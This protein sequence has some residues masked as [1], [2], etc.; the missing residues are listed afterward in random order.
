MELFV[1]D[2]GWWVVGPYP[3]NLAVSYPPESSPDLSKPINGVPLAPREGSSVLR[4]QPMRPGIADIEHVLTPR[5]DAASAAV[6]CRYRS[7]NAVQDFRNAGLISWRNA[8]TLSLPKR[9]G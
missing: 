8:I 1:L 9:A 5:T 3:S 2:A 7:H 4:W 6:K